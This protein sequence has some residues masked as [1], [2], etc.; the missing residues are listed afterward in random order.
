[1]RQNKNKLER[2]LTAA[3]LYLIRY[4]WTSKKGT[5]QNQSSHR[6]LS[7]MLASKVPTISFSRQSAEKKVWKLTLPSNFWAYKVCF[8][9]MSTQKVSQYRHKSDGPLASIRSDLEKY[10]SQIL[11]SVSQCRARTFH[12][13]TQVPVYFTQKLDGTFKLN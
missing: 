2:L 1:M 13:F 11:A 4:K 7:L 10:K 6:S 9:L 12:V 8:T 3:M 5:E